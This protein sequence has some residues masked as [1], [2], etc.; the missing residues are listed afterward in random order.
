MRLPAL[1]L[2]LV[3]MMLTACA[4]YTYDT[5]NMTPEQRAAGAALLLGIMSSM[6]QPPP[7]G[8]AS[9]PIYINRG[10][11][12]GGCGQIIAYGC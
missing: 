3:A 11:G 2:A 12:W 7:L 1:A 8:S 9:N 5:S 10:S 6:N 4:D